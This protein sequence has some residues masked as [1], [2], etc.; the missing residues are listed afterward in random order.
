MEAAAAD[1]IATHSKSANAET[2]TAIGAAANTASDSQ[3]NTP[4]GRQKNAAPGHRGRPQAH[5]EHRD[6][7]HPCEDRKNLATPM[8]T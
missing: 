2:M 3:R 7:L 6:A 8:N 5:G 4:P 1:A